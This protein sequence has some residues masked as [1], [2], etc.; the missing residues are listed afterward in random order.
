M[1]P[2]T[3]PLLIASLLAVV[4]V[5]PS[6]AQA[7]STPIATFEAE[8]PLEAAPQ[9]L[10]WSA[11]I[12]AA[13]ASLGLAKRHSHVGTGLLA[14]GIIGVASAGLFLAAFC[15]APETPCGGYEYS[16]ALIYIA[17]PITA[18]GGLIGALVP[19]KN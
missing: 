4:V 19:T 6:H 13:E 3:R 17:L 14:G 9:H 12:P 7:V 15:D 1:R 2:V 16:R 11:E 10:T 18:A 5:Q 8:L